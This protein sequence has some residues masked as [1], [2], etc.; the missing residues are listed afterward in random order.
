MQNETP[1]YTKQTF[2]FHSGYEDIPFLLRELFVK[3]GHVLSKFKMISN[4]TSG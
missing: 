3:V 2:V 1:D 4:F